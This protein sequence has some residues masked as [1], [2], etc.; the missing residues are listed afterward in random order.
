MQKTVILAE[1][2]NTMQRIIGMM[3][4]PL[5]LA[6]RTA[7][8]GEAA[9]A[10]AANEAPALL[11]TD[12]SL[13]DMDGYSVAKAFHERAPH[14]TVLLM[15]SAFQV[16]DEAL[17][18]VSFVD[19]TVQKPFD[20]GLMIETVERLIGEAASRAAAAANAA[21]IGEYVEA[22]GGPD[23][24][25]GDMWGGGGQS[26]AAAPEAMSSPEAA[27]FGDASTVSADGSSNSSGIE[28][29][30]VVVRAATVEVGEVQAPPS[31][32]ELP[33]PWDAA[34]AVAQASHAAGD[35][36]ALVAAELP[37]VAPDR[38]EA[39]AR[40]AIERAVWEI[41]PQL[42]ERIVREEINR[43]LRE[44]AGVATT[45]GASPTQWT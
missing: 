35:V 22:S 41:V 33:S 23:P 1:D 16:Y 26:A 5:G 43:L 42:A 9:L 45:Q 12:V 15:T 31:D 10:E 6:I 19:A 25:F 38:L 28:E 8:S 40:E 34:P 7:A 4:S 21:P 3:L 36:A 13:P 2:S 24:A 18:A 14:A 17:G 44:E 32:E 39:M 11:I 29:P 20:S 37:G 27:F 30:T